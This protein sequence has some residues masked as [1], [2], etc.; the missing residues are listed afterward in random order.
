LASVLLSACAS[1]PPVPYAAFLAG[2]LGTVE[3]YCREWI[4]KDAGSTALHANHLGIVRLLSGDPDEARKLFFSAGRS[5][6]RSRRRSCRRRPR[7][8]RRR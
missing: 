2:D 5:S 6:R 4:D 1:V 3:S 7:R 8:R